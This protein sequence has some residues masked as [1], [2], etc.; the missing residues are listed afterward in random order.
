[1]L[2]WVLIQATFNHSNKQINFIS[3]PSLWL[4]VYYMELWEVELL[5]E[6]LS[7]M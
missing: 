4:L 6:E 3:P 5:M 1:M 2:F 7:I